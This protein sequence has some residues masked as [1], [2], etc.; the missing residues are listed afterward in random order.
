MQDPFI[1]TWRLNP[2]SSAFDP[3]HRPTDGTMTWTLD[4]DGSY[5]LNAE[6]VNAKGEKVV[7]RPQRMIPDGRGYPIQDF[8]G[9]T[10]VTTRIDSHTIRVEGRR[11]DDSIAGEGTYT[12]SAD[13]KSMTA[14]TAGFDTQLRRFETR[15]AWDR[16]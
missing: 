15:T 10:T 4:A 2:A 7:E 1:G 14:M 12:V 5:T 9:L 13:G 3:N 11:E 6:G 8:P 16:L